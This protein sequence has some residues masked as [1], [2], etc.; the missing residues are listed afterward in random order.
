MFDDL[1]E[2]WREASFATLAD[3]AN[4]RAFKPEDWGE[5]GLPIIRIAQITNPGSETNFYK[6]AVEPRHL[7]DDGDLIFSWSA[8]LAVVRWN[9]GPAVLNQHLFKVVPVEGIDRD[10]LQYRLEASIPDLAD[11]AH[12]TTMKHIRKGTLTSKTTRVPPLD[13]Q[14]RIAEVLR[15]VDEVI[16][17]SQVIVKQGEALW[18][19][20]TDALIWNLPT[21][22]PECV[23]SLGAALRGTDYGVNVPLTLDAIGHPVLRMGNIQDG[24]IDLSDLK[25]GDIPSR[26]VEGLALS[27]GDIL[28]NR[29]NS[30]D[31][32]G[33]VA[34][35]REPTDCLYAS[36]IVRLSVDL[37]VA[38]PYYLFAA[39]H[40][41]RAQSAIKSIATP[42]VSQSNINPTNLKKHSIPLP[43]LNTQRAIADLLRSVEDARLRSQQELEVLQLIKRDLAESLLSGR[44]RVPA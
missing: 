11:E 27:V 25:W 18:Q 17:A 29:T 23:R 8:T 4:G 20:L 42:G 2:E 1:Q 7:I 16:L 9:G 33:K 36:Y 22:R 13:E 38:D 26:E 5:V 41:D 14:R 24:R 40:S 28:F 37:S 3:Y 10:W 31:L 43:D 30:R 12:G 15:S 32:V 34:L 39:M 19:G 6:G 35:V 21:D 44:V